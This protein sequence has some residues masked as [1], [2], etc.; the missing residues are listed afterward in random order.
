[1]NENGLQSNIAEPDLESWPRKR[2][3]ALDPGIAWFGVAIYDAALRDGAVSLDL[4]DGACIRTVKSDKKRKVSVADDDFHRAKRVS[5]E[6]MRLF[7]EHGV[8]M[9]V[10]EERSFPRGTAA[11]KSMAGAWCIIAALSYVLGLPVVVIP[12]KAIKLELCGREGASKAEVEAEVVRRFPIARGIAEV[13]IDA[14]ANNNHFFDAAAAGICGV[15]FDEI[16]AWLR[17]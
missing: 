16:L 9:L 12:P 15:R 5:A 2:L 3:A 10:A 7:T 14:G 1:M 6:L 4:I 8:G 17:D 11:I 13:T